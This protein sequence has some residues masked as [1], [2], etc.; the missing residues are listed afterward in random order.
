MSAIATAMAKATMMVTVKEMAT[1][2]ATVMATRRI[3][4]DK[5]DQHVL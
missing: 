1:T 4:V 3:N 5:A 2:T